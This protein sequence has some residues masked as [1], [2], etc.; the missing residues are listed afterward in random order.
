LASRSRVWEVYID[1]RL[2]ETPFPSFGT[3]LKDGHPVRGSTENVYRFLKDGEV[4]CFSSSEWH[5]VGAT[6]FYP[7]EGGEYRFRIQASAFQ[8]AS[9]SLTFR[10][11]ATG[12]P[13]TGKSGLVGYFDALPDKPTVYEFVRYMEQKTTVTMLPYGLAHASPTSAVIR[14]EEAKLAGF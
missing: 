10:V 2:L 1:S 9:K 3:S 8:S 4:V 13:L 6:Q 5:N 7:M 12:T 14:K 11:T